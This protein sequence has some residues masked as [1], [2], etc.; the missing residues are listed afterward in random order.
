MEKKYKDLYI[1]EILIL[2][3]YLFG[4][5]L[6]INNYFFL[7]QYFDL[8]FYLL[9][10]V[11]LY[12]KYGIAR[13]NNYLTKISVRYVIISLLSYI[14]IIYGF[15]LFTGFTKS[16]YDIS[17]LGVIRNVFPVILSVIFRELIRFSVAYNSKKDIKPFV[18]LTIIYIVIDILNLSFGS[19]FATFYQIF[20]FVCLI[21]LPAIAKQM[22]LS[23]ITYNINYIPS[24]IYSLAFEVAPFVLPIYP[25]LGD[26]LNAV[27]GL[28]FP[29]LVFFAIKKLVNYKE[30]TVIKVRGYFFK[31]MVI[32]L[33]AFLLVIIFLVSGLF[34]YKMIAIGSDSMNPIYY[35]GDAVIYQKTDAQNIKK[36]DILVFEYNS[37]V[38]THRVVN[39]INNGGTLYFQTKGDNNEKADLELVNEDNVLGKVRYIVKYVGYPTVWLNEKF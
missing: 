9:L 5:F 16:I 18:L 31:I 15:G 39:I 20:Q 34:S 3:L 36:G 22:L 8:I 1:I 17:F 38:I 28:L 25:D 37:S 32:P 27:I 35:R 30:K 4:K 11:F 29:F 10:F 14:L 19:S 24:M 2:V 33:I 23:Y 6:I 21:V 12:F 26:Y 13:D 7:L